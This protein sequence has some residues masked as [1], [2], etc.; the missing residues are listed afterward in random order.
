MPN[1]LKGRTV[2]RGELTIDGEQVTPTPPP[3]P[4]PPLSQMFDSFVVKKE[5]ANILVNDT[6]TEALDELEQNITLTT[7][8]AG[9]VVNWSRIS[10]NDVWSGGDLSYLMAN[11]GSSTQSTLFVNDHDLMN[12]GPRVSTS[13]ETGNLVADTPLVLQLQSAGEDISG[14]DNGELLVQIA[15]TVVE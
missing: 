8:P 9:A 11:L 12:P 1:Y 14:L 13:A 3:P 7:L 15:Y 10:H 5:G 6:S 4:P 2:Q